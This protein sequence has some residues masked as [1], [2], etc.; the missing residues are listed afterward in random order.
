MPFVLL[1]ADRTLW[2]SV[3]SPEFLMITGEPSDPVLDARH[4]FDSPELNLTGRSTSAF[5]HAESIYS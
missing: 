4:V 5:L 3:E 2:P 1:H